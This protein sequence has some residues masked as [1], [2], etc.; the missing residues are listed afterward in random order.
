MY[1]RIRYPEWQVLAMQVQEAEMVWKSFTLPQLL[2]W[3]ITCG[4]IGNDSLL[5]LF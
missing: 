3:C 1:C 2:E 4:T 5:V